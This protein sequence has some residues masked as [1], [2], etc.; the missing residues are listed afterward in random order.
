MIRTID[1][2]FAT[3]EVV[4]GSNMC[5]LTFNYGNCIKLDETN[6]T[7]SLEALDEGVEYNT[8]YLLDNI[9]YAFCGIQK[10]GEYI[11]AAPGNSQERQKGYT[12]KVLPYATGVKFPDRYFTYTEEEQAVIDQYKTEFD[13]YINEMKSKF[14]MGVEDISDDAAWDNYITTLN[15]LGLEQLRGAYQAAYERFNAE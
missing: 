15:T 1:I 3:E 13:S 12:E 9:V 5:G 8:T 7:Y 10:L 2:S 4:S 14:I 11:T 6:K